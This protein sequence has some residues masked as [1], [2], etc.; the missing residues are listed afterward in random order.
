[1]ELSCHT[2]EVGPLYFKVPYRVQL[3]GI[4][5]EARKELFGGQ[6]TIG[7]DG[8]KADQPNSV[9]SM[10]HYYLDT[11]AADKSLHFHAN[12]CTG[13]DKNKTV[14]GYL[15]WRCATGWSEQ[16]ELS[17]MRVGHTRSVKDGYFG[18]SK[19]WWRSTENETMEDVEDAVEKSSN[20]NN[21]VTFSWKWQEWDGFLL[22]LS[23][24]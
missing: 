7:P 23:S 6:L 18:L 8:K 5:Q 15:A 19:Q 12:N 3:F 20:A 14:L 10:L 16:I 17:S 21:A 4:V 1:M 13:Q 11:N 9:V 2:R 24:Q 22:Q